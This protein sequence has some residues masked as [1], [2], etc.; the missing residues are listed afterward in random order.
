MAARRLDLRKGEAAKKLQ[1]VRRVKIARKHVDSIY[2]ARAAVV[3]QARVRGLR[4]RH[5]AEDMRSAQRFADGTP[6]EAAAAA[7]ERGA[8]DGLEEMNIYAA[9]RGTPSG[10]A[11]AFR[12]RTSVGLWRGRWGNARMPCRFDT[13]SITRVLPADIGCC[14]RKTGGIACLIPSAHHCAFRIVSRWI[15]R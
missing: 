3:I 8:L 11:P 9:A 15:S 10:T 2:Q 14:S 1:S 4:G 6:A 7:A 12:D 13:I 5:L